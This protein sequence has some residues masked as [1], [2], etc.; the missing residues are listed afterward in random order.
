WLSLAPAVTAVAQS[1]AKPGAAK[2]LSKTQKKILEVLDFKVESPP[3]VVAGSVVTVTLKGNVKD[4]NWH[5]YPINKVAPDQDS[6]NEL[7]FEPN[8]DLQPVPEVKESDPQEK[9]GSDGKPVKEYHGAF[10][11]TVQVL[12]KPE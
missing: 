10:T 3:P 7:N 12:I 1:E 2:P 9:T 8:P 6:R 4:K 11:W 5:T